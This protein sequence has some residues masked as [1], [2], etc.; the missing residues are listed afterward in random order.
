MGVDKHQGY[1]LGQQTLRMT[2]C[3]GSGV[4]TLWERAL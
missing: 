1:S 4:V 3:S 2:L